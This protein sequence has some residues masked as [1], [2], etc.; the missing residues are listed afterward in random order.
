MAKVQSI[1]ECLEIKLLRKIKKWL[2][3]KVGF[4]KP[5]TRCMPGEKKKESGSPGL[6]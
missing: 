4:L 2:L 1:L 3:Q 6:E 5:R